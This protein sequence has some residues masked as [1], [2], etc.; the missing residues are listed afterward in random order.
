M[1]K[2]IFSKKNM[3]F[4]GIILLILIVVVVLAIVKNNSSTSME[5]QPGLIKTEVNIIENIPDGIKYSQYNNG[6]F[7]MKI[8]EGWVVET[9]KGNN[10][11]I[12]VYNP[13][14]ENYQLF[15]FYSLG[16]FLKNKEAKQYY[17]IYSN[18]SSSGFENLPVLDPGTVENVYKKWMTAIGYAKSNLEGYSNF[19]FPILYSYKAKEYF[20][21]NSKLEEILKNKTDGNVIRAEYTDTVGDNKFE[22]MFSAVIVDMNNDDTKLPYAVYNLAGITAEKGKL[23]D[24]ETVL[25][26]CFKSIKFNDKYVKNFDDENGESLVVKI[27]D[28]LQ[29]IGE[30]LEASWNNRQIDDDILFQKQLDLKQNVERVYNLQ[31]GKIYLVKKGW[32]SNYVGDEYAMITDD[33]YAKP[34]NGK[35]E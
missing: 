19:N 3:I 11:A 25:V 5:N 24:W 10:Y 22:G 21:L 31:S 1:I 8:P 33:M 4:C 2:D 14:N 18:I 17:Q 26:E 30:A 15:Y 35:I 34:V 9:V 7:S 16:G 32:F 28:E 6:D 12:R 23:I 13:E 29:I 27:T 20:E